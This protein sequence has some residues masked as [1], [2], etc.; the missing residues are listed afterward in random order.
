MRRLRARR[1]LHVSKI[2]NIVQNTQK[3][4]YFQNPASS[5][6]NTSFLWHTTALITDFCYGFKLEL[7]GFQQLSA[8][9]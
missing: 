7:V 2:E 5:T 1:A 3:N 6:P 4:C 8:V 9:Q